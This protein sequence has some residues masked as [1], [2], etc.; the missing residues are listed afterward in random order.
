MQLPP[1]EGRD[2]PAGWLAD[3]WEQPLAVCVLPEFRAVLISQGLA[4]SAVLVVHAASFSMSHG[5]GRVFG[6][7]PM[8][9]AAYCAAACPAGGLIWIGGVGGGAG[10]VPSS[11][12]RV[13]MSRARAMAR[14]ASKV[15]PL[16]TSIGR[17]RR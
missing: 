17:S 6:D 5:G 8:V 14:A 13:A 4:E 1:A 11:R 2:A 10:S 15:S 7:H 9:L 12:A 3:G 16:Q